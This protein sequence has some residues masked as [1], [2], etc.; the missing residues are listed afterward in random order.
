MLFLYFIVILLYPLLCA[1]LSLSISMHCF[2]VRVEMKVHN[3]CIGKFHNTKLN[4]TTSVSLQ[5]T[6]DLGQGLDISISRIVKIV[7]WLLKTV[8]K[9]ELG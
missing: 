1:L 6:N 5:L 7:S 8:T 2:Y 9:R 4:K 3:F